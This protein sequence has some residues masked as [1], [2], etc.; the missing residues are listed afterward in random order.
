[1][2]CGTFVPSGS[3]VHMLKRWKRAVL[4]ATG[5]RIKR[6][7]SYLGIF[8]IAGETLEEVISASQCLKFNNL[9]NCAIS[10]N[11][12]LFELLA[13]SL[14]NILTI[15]F[16]LDMSRTRPTQDKIP[17]SFILRRQYSGKNI[18]RSRFGFCVPSPQK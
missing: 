5:E 18:M 8:P 14:K 13:P 16:L 3:L 12:W 2:V 6:S 7:L 17:V 9:S 10:N 15:G 4:A 1:M 11:Y